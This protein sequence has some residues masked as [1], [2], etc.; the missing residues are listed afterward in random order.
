M[1]T[2][3]MATWG[4][5]EV[6]VLVVQGSLSHNITDQSFNNQLKFRLYG[7]HERYIPTVYRYGCRTIMSVEACYTAD[8]D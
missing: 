3:S 4:L 5:Q 2:L 7:I 6:Q 8:K 1:T